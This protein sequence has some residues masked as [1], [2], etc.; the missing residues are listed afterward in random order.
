MN[1]RMIGGALSGSS[2]AGVGVNIAGFDDRSKVTASVG[3]GCK[4]AAGEDILVSATAKNDV[5]AVTVAGVLGGP[6]IDSESG[7]IGG[8]MDVIVTGNEVSAT[9]GNGVTL[10]S[11]NGSVSILA[12]NL[13]DL[14]LASTSVDVAGNG[15][16]AGGTLAAA[17]SGNKTYAKA[18]EGAAITA[19]KD[20]TIQAESEENLINVLA[21]ASASLNKTSAAGVIGVLVSSSDTE[22]SVGDDAVIEAKHGAVS[23]LARSDVKQIVTIAGLTANAANP[24]AGATINVGVFE[25]SVT[26]RVGSGVKLLASDTAADRNVSVLA[27]GSNQTILVTVAGAAT[28]DTALAGTVPVVISQSKITTEIGDDSVVF[29]GDSIAIASDAQIGIYN[30]AGNMAI[31]GGSVGVGATVSTVVVQNQICTTIGDNVTLRAGAVGN[32]GVRLPNRSE[33]RRGVILS[34]NA[35]TQVLMASVSGAAGIGT[36]GVSGVV[37]TLV[38]KNTVKATVGENGVIEAGYSEE[39]AEEASG[40]DAEAAIESSDETDIYNLAGGISVGGSAGVGATVVTVV[41]DKSMEASVGAG[42]TLHASGSVRAAA[43]STD[44]VYL[45]ALSFAGSGTAGVSVGASALAF[46]NDLLATLGGTVTAG[47]NVDVTARSS[48]DLLNVATAFAAGGSAGVTPVAVVTWFAGSTVAEFGEGAVIQADGNVT[49]AADSE[50]FITSD[51]AGVSVG[52]AASV[53]GTVDILIS[54]Q[55]TRA[56]AQKNVSITGKKL[57]ISALDDT[58]IL[59][60]A[61]TGAFSGT[62][63]VGVTAVVSVLHNTVTAGMIGGEAGENDVDIGGTVNVLADAK[64]DV[65]SYAGSAAVSA[66]AGVGTT[67]MVTVAGGKLSQ[68]SSDALLM[69]GDRLTQEEYDALSEDEQEEYRKN[70]K[71]GFDPDGFVSNAFSGSYTLGYRMDGLAGKL[72]GDGVKQSDIQLGGK[73]GNFDAESGYVS[74]D[75]YSDEEVTADNANRAALTHLEVVGVFTF[76]H[77]PALLAFNL[78]GYDL[79]HGFPPM[80]RHSPAIPRTAHPVAAT[81]FPSRPRQAGYVFRPARPPSLAQTFR[82]PCAYLPRA[83]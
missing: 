9:V 22:A 82:F 41:Y 16:A 47:G 6:G 60:I 74:E 39:E 54:D 3:D 37:N 67:I 10:T 40:D 30:A 53:S 34:A 70:T 5:L 21:S 14:I 24:A 42:G 79:L 61:A 46:E 43:E 71:G 65:L 31:G 63:A 68:D 35:D 26:A 78:I 33:K 13:S 62:A 18:G 55:V 80:P 77:V 7:A 17:V 76:N 1:S 51:A 83:A 19:E 29:A 81:V 73:D 75:F 28:G 69:S 44:D 20:V 52:G 66:G 15:P 36:A 57:D 2:A 23:V 11:E 45:L 56:Q 72:E 25:Q 27:S 4:V 38:L 8:T 32:G 59:A 48:T 12:K 49:L 64:R 58:Q 50:E